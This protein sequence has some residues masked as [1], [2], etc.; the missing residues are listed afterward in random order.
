MHSVQPYKL[1]P[2][3]RARYQLQADLAISASKCQEVAHRRSSVVEVNDIFE[4]KIDP[5]VLEG[6]DALFYAATPWLTSTPLEQMVPKSISGP[7]NIIDQAEKAG[8]KSVIVT[9]SLAS[10]EFIHRAILL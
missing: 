3:H 5:D 9:G 7:L 6:V 4:D 10:G 1:L 2:R 8:V